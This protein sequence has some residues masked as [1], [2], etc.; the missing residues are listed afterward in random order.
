MAKLLVMVK[1]IGIFVTAM[2]AVLL[3]VGSWQSLSSL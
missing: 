1:R 3:V 2:T